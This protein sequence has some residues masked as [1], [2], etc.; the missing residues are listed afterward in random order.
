[1][2]KILLL[3]LLININLLSQDYME[4]INSILNETKIKFAPDKRTVLFDIKYE[5]NENNLI[6]KGET[7]KPEALREL[8]ERLV[9]EKF[10]VTNTVEL[11]PSDKLNGKINGIINLSVA[12]LRTE[13]KHPA[14]LATQALLGTKVKVLKK[15][16]DWYLVQTPDEYLSW[17]DD[18][19]IVLFNNK[20]LEKWNNSEKLIYTETFGIVRESSDNNSL[21]ISD[22]VAG[23]ILLKIADEEN[24]YFVSFPDGRKGY[25]KKNELKNYNEWLKSFEFKS[26]EIIETAKQFM[27]VPYL[28]GGTS[29]KGFDCSGFTKTVYF[30]NGIVLPR[31][32][33]QQIFVGELVD[34]KKEFNNL[35]PGDLVFFGFKATEDRKER[36]THVGIYMGDYKFIHA[37]GRVKINSF[38]KSSPLFS[39]FRYNTYIRSKRILSSINK[40]GVISIKN[41]E[42]YK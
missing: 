30:L 33:S 39:E 4:K 24:H 14:E 18:F 5:L 36:I 22:V 21:P 40:N 23:N 37:A 16:E 2:K 32:A 20:D 15:H 35:L 12:N 25:L 29:T 11:L 8:I 26:E 38:D 17:V 19:G 10:N 31:D 27:G 13:P 9:N 7:T 42:S 1:M 34:E 41:H 28:W 6:L 3:I